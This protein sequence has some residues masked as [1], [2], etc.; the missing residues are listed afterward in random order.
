MWPKWIVPKDPP[1]D[2][3]PPLSPTLTPVGTRVLFHMVYGGRPID[4]VVREWSP[5]G[6]LVRVGSEWTYAS[7]RR[8]ISIL[9]PKTTDG[10]QC[11]KNGV[12]HDE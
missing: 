9:P 3:H 11:D 1:E 7:S 6:K 12:T 10:E 2:V 4:G 8:L 5:D